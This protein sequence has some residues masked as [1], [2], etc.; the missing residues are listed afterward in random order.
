MSKTP[1][2][3]YNEYKGQSINFDHSKSGV[4]CVDGFKVFLHWIGAKVITTGTGWADGY[5][6]YRNKN[7]LAENFEF[8]EDPR[9]FKTGDWVIWCSTKRAPEDAAPPFKASKSHPKSHVSMFFEGKEFGE[10]GSIPRGFT[11]KR[12]DFSDASGAFRWKEWAYADIYRLYNGTDM[13]HFTPSAKE[14]DALVKLGWK[15]E[16]VAWVA[17]RSGMSVYCVYNKRNGDHLLTT[18]PKECGRLVSYGLTMEGIKFYGGGT[19]PVYRLY[20]KN[21]GEHFYTAN[22]KEYET[23]VKRGVDGEGIAFYA[24][25]GGR[26]K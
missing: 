21:T 18:N 26:K 2:D 3:F 4:Q 24:L 19:V 8:I 10:S 23:L 17:P 11:L 6:Y 12:T 14:R 22:S 16:G 25:K 7:G 15:Y 1:F 20:N 5:W 13:H 9:E